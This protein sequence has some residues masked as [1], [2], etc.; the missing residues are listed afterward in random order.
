ML[1]VSRT[2][3]VP[4]LCFIL[5]LTEL[6]VLAVGGWV[7]GCCLLGARKALS[8]EGTGEF[9]IRLKLAPSL[10][11]GEVC[12]ALSRCSSVRLVPSGVNRELSEGFVFLKVAGINFGIQL[13]IASLYGKVGG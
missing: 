6:W 3:G 13:C 7:A 4:P 5:L 9:S 10:G 8:M 12:G 1:V 11:M 2:L